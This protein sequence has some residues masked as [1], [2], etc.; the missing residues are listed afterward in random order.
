MFYEVVIPAAGQGKRMGAGQNK[1]FIE[2]QSIPVIIHTLR[3]FDHDPWCKSIILVINEKEKEQFERLLRHYRIQK[4]A[5]MVN[6]GEER[7]H[8]V[9]NGL[10][11]VKDADI[12]LIHDGAR[13]FVTKSL[14]H[15]LVE[16][17]QQC[18]A[19]IAAVPV[20]DTIKRVKDF[21][22]T[23]TVERS[24][25]WS[26]QTPQ[27]FRRSLVLQ[28]HE[29]AKKAGYIGTDDASLVERMGHHV[30]IVEGDY[31]NIKL[32]TPED[33]IFAEAI[34]ANRNLVS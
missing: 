25:L 8:S 29:Q 34:L 23:E 31:Q 9:Y 12:V 22:V 13:P 3:V 20:K 7:Q 16:S 33:L 5:A 27:A 10:L 4:V 6:G 1:Q 21:V 15:R 28:A 32:T 18:G 19:A 17:V 14:I 30:K 2:L 24:S 26:V 11:A